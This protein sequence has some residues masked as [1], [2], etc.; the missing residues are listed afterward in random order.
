MA[1]RVHLTPSIARA[2]AGGQV[3]HE[4]EGREIR[5]LVRALDAREG[6]EPLVF[7][8]GDFGSF[9]PEGEPPA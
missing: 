3:E 1:A 7:Y 4:V 9:R 8:R 6:A 2:F 5:H